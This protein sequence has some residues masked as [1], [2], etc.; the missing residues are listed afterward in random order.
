MINLTMLN[1]VKAMNF[2]IAV[3]FT[4]G[5]FYQIVYT[6]IGLIRKNKQPVII[7]SK[8]HKFAAL[9]CARNEKEVIYEIVASLK[10]QK[11]PKNFSMCMF[12]RIIARIIR[13]NSQ[14]RR[15]PLSMNVKTGSRSARDMRWI[16]F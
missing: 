13:R 5:Y 9:I 6:V 8:L 10:R 3:L 1:M 12:L 16:T 15:A 14:E 4:L 11:Y 2:A 7:P